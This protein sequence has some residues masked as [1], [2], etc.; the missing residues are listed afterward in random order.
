MHTAQTARAEPPLPLS[1]LRVYAP[2][3]RTEAFPI[4]SASQSMSTRVII[5]D[6]HPMIRV[7]VRLLLERNGATVVAEA[8]SSDTLLS[9][10]GETRCDLLITDFSMPDGEAADGLALLERIRRGHT[11]LPVIVLTMIRNLGVLNNILDTGIRGLVDK[12]AG[13]NELNLAVQAVIHGRKYISTTFRQ[14]LDE[15]T[16]GAPARLSAREAEVLRLFASGLTVSGIAE[17]VSRSVKTISRQKVNA[18]TKLG[19]K[20]DLDI[21]TY[22]REHGLIS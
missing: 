8:S 17:R 14:A 15:A 10:L 9:A 7:G 19:L 4:E 1:P 21:Y 3:G 20:S 22:A 16:A 5:A 6:D 18:M 13:L 2:G 12:A 11:D